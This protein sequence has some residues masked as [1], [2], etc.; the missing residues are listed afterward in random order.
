MEQMWMTVG[1]VESRRSSGLHARC[2]KA[3]FKRTFSQCNVLDSDLE[4][5]MWNSL[6]NFPV[7]MVSKSMIAVLM[8]LQPVFTKFAGR[9]TVVRSVKHHILD[10]T[11]TGDIV[12]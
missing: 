6:S 2:D 7:Y 12:H 10:N 9:P 5:N 8:A 11:D 1:G 4:N 3:W